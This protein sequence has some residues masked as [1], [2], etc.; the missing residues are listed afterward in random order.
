MPRAMNGGPGG[1]GGSF[2]SARRP[3]LFRVFA[4]AEA[5]PL[6]STEICP[7]IPYLVML[8]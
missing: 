1:G 3:V 2:R 5:D 8:F 6:V 4:M 7:C